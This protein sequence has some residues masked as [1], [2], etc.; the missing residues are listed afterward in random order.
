MNGRPRQRKAIANY[1]KALNARDSKI[2]SGLR[3]L[4]KGWKQPAA[5]LRRKH[6]KPVD[7][8]AVTGS[9]GKSTTTRIIAAALS[10]KS[11][12]FHAFGRNTADG[13]R[14][15]F[16]TMPRNSKIWVQEVSGHTYE[17]MEESL[18]FIKPTVGVVTMIGMDH[19]SHYKTK[20]A[21]ADSKG[22]LVEVLP[23]HGFAVLNADD[24][25]VAQ[26]AG[27][28]SA[29]VV[30]FGEHPGAD[31]RLIS[32]RHGL[33][34]R[35]TLRVSIGNQVT[36]VKTRF[37]GP[38]W[39]VSVMA[40]IAAVYALGVSLEETAVLI[41][42]VE[43]ELFKDD[44]YVHD[45]VT[46]VMDSYKAPVW[47]METSIEILR[48]SNARRKLML[49]GSLSDYRG[50]ARPKYVQSAR[51]ALEVAQIVMFYGP[52]A[53]RVR[54]LVPEFPDRIFMFETFPELLAFVKQT[55]VNGD[56]FYVK[57]SGADHLERIMYEFQKPILCGLTNCKKLFTCNHCKYLYRKQHRLSRENA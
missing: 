32:H 20:E 50:S 57:A 34:E 29:K 10:N 23:S 8:V 26:M 47:S 44:V 49:I 22:Q 36:D 35:L 5:Q 45:G 42:Q 53:Q 54:R 48:A 16:L 12:V 41:G 3:F 11:D 38:R 30:T 13:I 40:A 39:T 9:A 37:V 55:L 7:I 15:S 14:R 4:R 33:P 21:I 56:V 1:L 17:A 25:L 46:F 28:T 27:R 18:Q 24:P 19:I 2:R 31:V 43:P 52:H 6:V 51:A